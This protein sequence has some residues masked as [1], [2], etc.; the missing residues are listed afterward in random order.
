MTNL[1][2]MAAPMAIALLAAACSSASAESGPPDTRALLPPLTTVA[3]TTTTPTEALPAPAEAD[4]QAQSELRAVLA[5][6]HELYSNSGTF[7]AELQSVAALAGVGVVTLEDAAARPAVVYDAHD[8]RLTLH[9]QSLSGRWFCVDV[10]EEGADHGFGDTFPDALSTCTDNVLLDGWREV[11]SPTGADEASIKALAGS[12]AAALETVD[13]EAAHAVFSP[14]AACTPAS[15]QDL[16][17]GIPLLQPDQFDVESII[18]DGEAASAR[19]MLGPFSD[20]EWHLVYIE[21]GWFVDLDPCALLAPEAALVADSR[22]RNLIE[23]ALFEVRTAFVAR[24]HLDFTNADLAE[25]NGDLQWVDLADAGYGSLSYSGSEGLGLLVTGNGAGRFLCAVESLATA[26]VY[27]EGASL[28][29]V[30]TTGR[31]R[32]RATS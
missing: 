22:S 32:S 17:P 6:A 7:D 15:L 13:V 16:W 26:T 14:E 9:R 30:N 2:R 28:A 5:A 25:L 10:T 23:Q 12:L 19:L 31:C 1:R 21:G 24:S 11:F 18:V 20:R 27:G 29:E 8:R 3:K 4:R